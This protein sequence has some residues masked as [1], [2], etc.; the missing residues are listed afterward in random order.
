MYRSLVSATIAAITEMTTEAI[1]N[2]N[3]ARTVVG[4]APRE[5][6]DILP[7]TLEAE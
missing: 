6:S 7:P 5:T 1:H 3:D 2:Q 4:A